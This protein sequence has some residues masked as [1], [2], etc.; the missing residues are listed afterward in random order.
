MK[1]LPNETIRQTAYAHRIAVQIHGRRVHTTFSVMTDHVANTYMAANAIV[2]VVATARR[3]EPG[4]RWAK[5][6][7]GEMSTNTSHMQVQRIMKKRDR[8]GLLES[9]L[10]GSSVPGTRRSSSI[11]IAGRCY[12]CREA[13]PRRQFRFRRVAAWEGSHRNHRTATRVPTAPQASSAAR[14]PQAK[15]QP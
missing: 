9:W 12:A 14:S 8:S 3:A 10:F 4:F 5:S 15:P 7:I 2:A 1:S 11:L 13:V 6:T